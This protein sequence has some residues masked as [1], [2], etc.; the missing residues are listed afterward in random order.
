MINCVNSNTVIIY[1]ELPTGGGLIQ[2]KRHRQLLPEEYKNKATIKSIPIYNLLTHYLEIIRR[3]FFDL[4]KIVKRINKHKLIIAYQSWV[5]KAPFFLPFINTNIIYICNEVPR[6][7]FDQYIIDNFSF[8]DKLINSI[9]L[10]PIKKLDQFLIKKSKN[11]TIV[12]ISKL[13][14]S[15]IYKAYGID[16]KVIYPGIELIEFGNYLNIKNRKNQII[17]VGAINKVKN[18]LYILRVLKDIPPVDRPNLVIVGNGCDN[19][20]LNSILEYSR[21]NKIECTIYKNISRNKLIKLYKESKIFVYPS[22]NE[23]FGIAVLEALRAGLPIITSNNGGFREVTDSECGYYLKYDTKLWSS[24]ITSLIHKKQLWNKISQ[25]NYKFASK[26]S[27]HKHNQEL[28]NII[29]NVI[30]PPSI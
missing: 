15:Q 26:F 10:L 4:D 3:Y 14:A 28:I 6:E 22:V 21:Q 2:Y 5:T 16:S 23:P 19:K 20:Y 1:E 9:F 29:N 17:T 18:Q 27:H 13:S 12:T 25:H 7:F 24:T 30:C 8:K 11:I